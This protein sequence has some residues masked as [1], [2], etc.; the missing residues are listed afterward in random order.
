M[1]GACSSFQFGEDLFDFV[2]NHEAKKKAIA[3]VVESEVGGKPQRRT[4]GNI[5]GE[6]R[7]EIVG[8]IAQAKAVAFSQAAI[9]LGHEH[10]VFEAKEA[11]FRAGCKGQRTYG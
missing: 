4:A 8:G 9:H 1:A 2:G 10:E 7:A 6:N 5:P 11:L 3:V